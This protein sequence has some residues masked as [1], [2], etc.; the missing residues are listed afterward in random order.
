MWVKFRNWVN[1]TQRVFGVGKETLPGAFFFG[2]L[3]LVGVECSTAWSV[4]AKV[5][6]YKSHVLFG[7]NIP[8]SFY[9]I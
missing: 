4:W 5:K 9:G 6:F 2:K 7:K 3:Y 8:F 1:Y